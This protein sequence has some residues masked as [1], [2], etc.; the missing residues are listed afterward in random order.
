MKI[1]KTP[2]L[3]FTFHIPPQGHNQG[4]AGREQESF[5]RLKFGIGTVHNGCIGGGRGS[6]K[7]YGDL[8]SNSDRGRRQ[9]LWPQRPSEND[10]V[11][12]KKKMAMIRIKVFIFCFVFG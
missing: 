11:Y 9:D 1:L 8:W 7:G 2:L 4:N 10:H 6:V 5:F 12:Q 3:R